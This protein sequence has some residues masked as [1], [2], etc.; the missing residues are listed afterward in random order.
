MKTLRKRKRNP[1]L[2]YNWRKQ[3]SEILVQQ[4]ETVD[5]VKVRD[6]CK[7]KVGDQELAKKVLAALEKV[8]AGYRKVQKARLKLQSKVS[9]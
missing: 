5:S 4:G 6:I 9:A 2:P 8:K 7:G 3:V 1:E